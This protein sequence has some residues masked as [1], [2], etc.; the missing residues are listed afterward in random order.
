MSKSTSQAEHLKDMLV[1]NILA[2]LVAGNLGYMSAHFFALTGFLLVALRRRHRS[3]VRRADPTGVGDAFR[4][5]FLTGLAA[6]AF[7]WF[8][9]S[10][11]SMMWMAG[12]HLASLP[13]QIGEPPVGVEGEDSLANAVEQVQ[14]LCGIEQPDE[15]W[16]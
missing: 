2:I 13:V 6:V 12:E 15:P 16:Q 5:G 14:W 7:L 3:E 4:A 11:W 9:G 8:L 1:G 10:L